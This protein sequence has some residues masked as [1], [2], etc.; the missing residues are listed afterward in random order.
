MD[1]AT[2][3]CSVCWDVPHPIRLVVD[4]N[5]TGTLIRTAQKGQKLQEGSCGPRR[6][7]SP[8]PRCRASR[9]TIKVENGTPLDATLAFR[10]QRWTGK[11]VQQWT[12][13]AAKAA[14]K[15]M[16]GD[17][18]PTYNFRAAIADRINLEG[19]RLDR[20]DKAHQAIPSP[21]WSSSTLPLVRLPRT[22]P[23]RSPTRC[24]PT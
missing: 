19:A 2:H 5:P 23:R 8:R 9:S 1:A 11:G 10:G 24:T 18:D 12:D 17:W 13:E 15:R 22:G 20:V 21:R 6:A 7:P 3:R 4:R 16:A 14:Q